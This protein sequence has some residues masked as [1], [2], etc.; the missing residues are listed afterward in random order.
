MDFTH[1]EW[2]TALQRKTCIVHAPLIGFICPPLCRCVKTETF[3]QN[4]LGVKG[5]V[6]GLP[7]FIVS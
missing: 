4:L 1:N 5:I 7:I 6:I 2:L 3:N